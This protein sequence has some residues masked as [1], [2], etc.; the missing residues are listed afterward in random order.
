MLHTNLVKRFAPSSLF[1]VYHPYDTGSPNFDFN[2][3]LDQFANAKVNVA[4]LDVDQRKEARLHPLYTGNATR[5]DVEETQ[6]IGGRVIGRIEHDLG[7]ADEAELQHRILTI[8]YAEKSLGSNPNAVEFVRVIKECAGDT[9][10]RSLQIW[11]SWA[12]DQIKI[13]LDS[14]SKESGISSAEHKAQVVT[15]VLTKL[16]R[17][18][19]ELTAVTATNE[20]QLLAEPEVYEFFGREHCYTDG[21][22]ECERQNLFDLRCRELLDQQDTTNPFTAELRS[23][24]K[25]ISHSHASSTRRSDA[26]IFEGHLHDEGASEDDLETLVE[27][28]ERVTEQYT[29]DGAT[30]LHMSDGERFIVDGTLEEDVDQ[31]Y[32]PLQ[33]REIVPQLH[34]LFTNGTKLS[35][36]NEDEYTISTFIEHQLNLI[37]GSRADREARSVRTTRSI[38]YLPPVLRTLLPEIERLLSTTKDLNI[39]RKFINDAVRSNLADPSTSLRT[40]EEAKLD[41]RIYRRLRED[42]TV[43]GLK[44][45]PAEARDLILRARQIQLINSSCATLI[46]MLPAILKRTLTVDHAGLYEFDETTSVYSNAEERR[47]VEE[48]LSQILQNFARDFIT[49]SL[50]YS[51]MFRRF[52]EAIQAATDT[53]ALIACIK[54]AYSAYTVPEDESQPN[55]KRIFLS[56]LSVKLFT[57]L[58]TMYGARRAEL[59][60]IPLC[61]TSSEDRQFAQETVDLIMQH[62]ARGTAK[63]YPEASPAFQA[64]VRRLVT[65]S[66]IQLL[67]NKMQ[68]AR[69]AQLAGKLSTKMFHALNTLYETKTALLESRPFSRESQDDQLINVG[70]SLLNQATAI[71][72]QHL[73]KLA[74]Q[75]H[76]LPMQERER[77]RNSFREVRPELYKGIKDSLA[78]SVKSASPGKLMYLRFASYE[79]R[80]TGASNEP[81]NK[82]HLLTEEDKAEVWKLLNEKSGLPEPQNA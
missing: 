3:H 55:G 19:M 10:S 48:V 61:R 77:F 67:A 7:P 16:G 46:R 31:D 56:V 12:Y 69:E 52:S 32:L 18:A 68:T 29:E 9:D 76:T 40:T 1:L 51:P 47:Y 81:H 25:K 49:S 5:I 11:A 39:A 65:S 33:V 27:D 58:S 45:F 73:R 8:P 21:D 38:A 60:S 14:Y 35:S 57:A 78:E 72:E 20:E 4:N 36:K 24:A 80:T 43:L 23:I 66:D 74:I 30:S 75:M 42:I 17:M 71:Q 63:M 6:L 2:T 82:I 13:G 37:Y 64:A 79:D 54:A 34:E 22:D 53:R 44:S 62:M 50:H 26:E 59:E 15:A 41:L 70:A 28:F